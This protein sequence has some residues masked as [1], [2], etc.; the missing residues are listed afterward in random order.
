MTDFRPRAVLVG[1][2]HA[3]LRIH[4]HDAILRHRVGF[5]LVDFGIGEQEPLQRLGDL[6]LHFLGRRARINGS[7]NTL[8]DGELR[9]LILVQPRQR[10]NAEYNQTRHNEEDDLVAA[11]RSE[12]M[13]T[14]THS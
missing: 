7:H 4:I 5:L 12:D 9:E 2:R 6:L 10:E 13:V 3:Q 11:H 14:T 8:P 1:H